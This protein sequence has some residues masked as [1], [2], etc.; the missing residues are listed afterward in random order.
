M[1]ENQEPKPE[2]RGMDKKAPSPFAHLPITV[3]R[4]LEEL[5]PDEDDETKEK[6]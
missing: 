1:V 6:E 2:E 4:E 3:R 5:W